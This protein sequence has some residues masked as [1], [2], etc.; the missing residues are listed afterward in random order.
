MPADRIPEGRRVGGWAVDTFAPHGKIDRGRTPQI[1]P[2][3]FN[4]RGIQTVTV[5][6][7]QLAYPGP[8]S[9]SGVQVG[10]AFLKVDQPGRTVFIM[11]IS[12]TSYRWHVCMAELRVGGLEAGT[13]NFQTSSRP[14]AV[15]QSAKTIPLSV[16]YYPIEY[17]VVCTGS[18][19]T[20]SIQIR[21]ES[22]AR[23]RAFRADE[24][25]HVYR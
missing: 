10:R 15:A 9:V 23:P 17:A 22:D 5:P 13:L 21:D 25:F 6:A 14:T 1:L 11:E 8:G 2:S 3:Y 18:P 20:F 16:G 4:Q 24:L 7:D 19:T 12:E